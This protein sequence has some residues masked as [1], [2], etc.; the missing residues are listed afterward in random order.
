MMF[1]D[2][3]EHHVIKPFAKIVRVIPISSQQRPRE[4]I[5][6]LREATQA[7]RDGELLC[8]FPEG[9]MTRIGQM[10][11]FRRGLERIMKGVEAPIISV[12][13]D[14]VW[15]S[16][17]SFAGGKFLWKFPRKIPYPVQV[18]FGPP[19]PSSSPAQE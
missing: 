10:L 1:K 11:P 15:G 18:T 12:Y 4:M 6:S 19:L 14:G 3:Y 17:F 7:L 13:I 8:I 5:Y 9:Q 2:T 16:I